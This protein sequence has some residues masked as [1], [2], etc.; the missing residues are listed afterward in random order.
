M[1][2][3][4]AV[5]GLSVDPWHLAAVL[6]GLRLR[7]DGALRIIDR[8]MILDAARHA[9]GLHQW[10]TAPDFDQEGE[11]QRAERVLASASSGSPLLSVASSTHVWLNQGGTRP[12][13][14]AALIRYWTT[15]RLLRVPVPLTG[16]RAL[17]AGVPFDA[18]IWVP[19][20]LDALADEAADGLQ[21]LCD[22]ERSWFAARRAAAAGRRS[23]SRAAAAID[24]LA[25]APLASATTLAAGLGIA[26][27]NA[28][29]LLDWFAE[30]GIVVEV[31]RRSKRRLF[32]L[33]GLAPLRDEVAPPRRPEPGRGRG[34]PPLIKPEDVLPTL[35]LLERPLTQVERRP[36]D[37][38]DLEHW[39]A[40]ADQVIRDTRRSLEA[41]ATK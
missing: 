22:L 9:L 5:D 2:R 6:E 8:G 7:M 16:P 27:K 28:I 23:T 3:Q 25:A 15:H 10:I 1:R 40:H 39:M 20:F 38:S 29:A 12:P 36:I 18:D 13:I 26:V 11:V 35:P 34:R 19:I 4:A 17:G 41:L 32:G 24:I 31:T 30:A 14:R 37:Y 21:L 33:A